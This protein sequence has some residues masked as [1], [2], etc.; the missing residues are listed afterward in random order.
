MTF[1]KLIKQSFSLLII[2]FYY[3]L[4]ISSILSLQPTASAYRRNVAMEEEWRLLPPLAEKE[5]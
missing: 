2:I 4:G 5:T 1:F 3:Y